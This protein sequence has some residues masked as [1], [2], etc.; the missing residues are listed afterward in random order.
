[1]FNK[2][3]LFKLCEAVDDDGPEKNDF[4]F[5]VEDNS[6]ET[7]HHPMQFCLPA[8]LQGGTTGGGFVPLSL[9]TYEQYRVS[10]E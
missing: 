4:M 10:Q 6:H 3:C 5:L 2:I 7:S 9:Y 1:M 8:R